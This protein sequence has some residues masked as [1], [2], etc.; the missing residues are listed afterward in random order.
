MIL[1]PVGSSEQFILLKIM[2]WQG[3][4]LTE[5]FPDSSSQNAMHA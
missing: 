5:N 3:G 4:F 2:E 1:G